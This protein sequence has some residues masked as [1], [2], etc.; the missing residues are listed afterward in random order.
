M[1]GVFYVTKDSLVL[2]PGIK[3]VRKNQLQSLLSIHE[4]MSQA[5][6]KAQEI[7]SKAEESYRARFEEGFSDGCDAGHKEYAEK[8]IDVAVGSLNALSSVESSL[9]AVVIKSVKKILG[10]FESDEVTVKLIKNTLAQV[11]GENRLVLR[12]SANDAAYVRKSLEQHLISS[13]GSSGYIEVIA[14]SGLKENS[15]I[16]ETALGIIDSS[17]DT[18][19]EQLESLFNSQFVKK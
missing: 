7:I 6:I 16:L 17:L 4:A 3:I 13:D 15:C 10:T 18:Q 1:E 9:V 2:E 12:V 11:R 8:M 19:L 5:E 14:D